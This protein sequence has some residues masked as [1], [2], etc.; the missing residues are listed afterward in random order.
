MQWSCRFLA[1][2][3][4]AAAFLCL[5]QGSWPPRSRSAAG[6]TAGVV[7]RPR[8]QGPRSEDVWST[9]DEMDRRIDR[10]AEEIA[11]MAVPCGRSSRGR[12]ALR[13]T[14]VR[15]P[16]W[17]AA[18]RPSSAA[19]LLGT[20]WCSTG[21]FTKPLAPPGSAAVGAAHGETDRAGSRGRSSRTG[22]DGDRLGPS[23]G[24]TGT[25]RVLNEGHSPSKCAMA[26]VAAMKASVALRTDHPADPK[27]ES[28]VPRAVPLS[29]RL[30]TVKVIAA[31]RE[32]ATTHRLAKGIEAATRTGTARISVS[33]WSAA[34]TRGSSRA[35]S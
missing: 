13:P 19:T 4:M 35:R 27:V 1:L 24:R 5:G 3:W 18:A 11:A 23:V 22:R 9:V 28:G 12:S 31:P 32:D 8:D 33:G 26:K 14:A 16:R 21:A 20:S 10:L 17:T 34:R 6:P 25:N 29:A 15:G 30:R 7:E 2:S